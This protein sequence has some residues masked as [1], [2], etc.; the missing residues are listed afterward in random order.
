MLKAKKIIADNRYLLIALLVIL[1]TCTGLWIISG[2]TSN[3]LCIADC[4]ETFDSLQYVSNYQI[5][6]LKYG[7]VQDLATSP[8]P[9]AH[10]YFYTHNANIAGY[11][12]T[13]LE[14]IGLNQLW[15]KQFFTIL[16]FGLG[17]FYIFR[18]VS[19]YSSSKLAGFVILFLF[20]TEYE[21]VLA[22][23]LNSLRAFHWL[24]IFGLLF[25]FKNIQLARKISNRPISDY[26]F[27]SLFAIISFCLGYDFWIIC[28]FIIFWLILFQIKRPLFSKA[29]LSLVA[30]VAFTFLIP[31]VLRQIQVI[32]GLGFDF[33]A[34]DFYFSAAIKVS[35]LKDF[36]PIPSIEQIDQ[37]YVQYNVLRPPASQSQSVS[38]ILITLRDMFV[39]ITG[40]SFGIITTTLGMLICSV[41]IIVTIIVNLPLRGS[42]HKLERILQIQETLFNFEGIVELVAGLSLGI[43][44][45]LSFFAPLSFHIYLKHQF[46]LIAVLFLLPKAIIITI[47]IQLLLN[48][49]KQGTYFSAKS[50]ILVIILFCIIT[51]TLIVQYRNISE[52]KPMDLSWI[53]TV[54]DMPGQTFAVSWIPSSVSVFSEN[55]SVGVSIGKEREILDRFNKGSKS[56]NKEDYFLFGERDIDTKIDDYLHPS[57]WLYF[58]TEHLSYF[59]SPVPVC[60]QDY[61]LEFTEKLFL[62]PYPKPILLLDIRHRTDLTG[63]KV[64][65]VG[66]N[67]GSEKGLQSISV[68]LDH[69]FLDEVQYNCMY[70]QY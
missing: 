12:F 31:F 45:G 30:I 2:S 24:A 47:G 7:L 23:G 9:D 59:D 52:K 3:I 26:L 49:K 60:R 53:E 16:I 17:L 39:N 69:V 56:F 65:F 48:S 38:Q 40:P 4:G 11:F 15:A 41:A 10:P 54:N 14:I 27:F 5:Y 33:W 51:D 35:Y 29:N 46:P 1:I 44:F 28:I 42:L 25:H 20:C 32:A 50:T 37:F 63:G 36:L 64:F 57:F 18:T 34:K 61:L 43:I 62:P 8:N 58:P 55:W 19:L 66:K 6:G 21:H 13:L 70:D 67:N 22:Y 68:E